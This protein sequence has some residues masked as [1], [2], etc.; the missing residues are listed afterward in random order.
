MSLSLGNI[1]IKKWDGV[2]SNAEQNFLTHSIFRYFGKLPPVLTS[3]ILQEYMPQ[4]KKNERLV[5]DLM[6][7]SGTTLVEAQRLGVKSIGV[8]SN[9]LALLISRVKTTPLEIGAVQSA[10]TKF[11][12]DF[13]SHLHGPLFRVHEM[14]EDDSAPAVLSYIPKFK[15]INKWFSPRVQ[16]DL[17]ICRKWIENFKHNQSLYEFM[18]LSWLSIIRSSSNASVRTGRIFLDKQ[19]ECQSVFLSL[20]FRFEKYMDLFKQIP[21]SHFSP[22]PALILG[23][24]RTIQLPED[25]Y[26]DLTFFH[27]PYFALYKYSSDVLRF[28]LEW[29]QY[30]RKKILNREIH[31]GFKT[32]DPEL[33]HLYVDDIFQAIRNCLKYTKKGGYLVIVIGNSTLAEKQLPII[34]NILEICAPNEIKYKEIIERPIN[35]SQASYHRSANNNIKSDSDF[36]LVFKR[37]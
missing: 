17:A 2:G 32:S 12:K 35:F 20:L 3:R 9:D 28:E 1:K 8:D 30:D 22:L 33:M 31:D 36:I 34:P 24:A 23:D 15:N 14:K 26:A 19:K 27:P 11:R 29:G 5:I 18:F 6:C 10:I 13:Q 7:G 25:Q 4:S 16:Y 21:K 37:S